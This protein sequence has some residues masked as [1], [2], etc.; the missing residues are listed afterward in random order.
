MIFE[1][2]SKI[3]NS[4]YFRQVKYLLELGKASLQIYTV[5]QKICRNRSI[6][7]SFRDTSIFVFFCEKFENS[8]WLP[9]WQDKIFWKLGQLLRRTTL[10]L[11][12]FVKIMLSSTVFEIRVFLCFVIFAKNSKIQNGRLF[13]QV[14]YLL[15]L[16]KSSLHKYPVGQKFC[17][18]PTSKFLLINWFQ[19]VLVYQHIFPFCVLHFLSKIRKLIMTPIFGEEK[20]FEKLERVV[21]LITLWVENL[22]E[23]A[24]SRTVEIQA[25]LCFT[26]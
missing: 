12:N 24:L 4:R 20:F 19:K 18:N 2:N 14:K 10:W 13:W 11:K 26:C 25:V 17:R 23:I 16:G 3:Q 9:F 22:D 6:W 8:K 1:K 5:D 7:H 21:C 15:K